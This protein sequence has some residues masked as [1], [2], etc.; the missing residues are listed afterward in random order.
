LPAIEIAGRAIGDG[1]PCFVIAEAGVN[2]N[3][4][5]RLARELVRVAAEAG[6]DAVKFQT[7]AAE[8]LATAAAPKASYQVARTERD[9][10]AQAMLRRLELD[11]DDHVQLIA[12]C[13]SAGVMFLSSA[14]DEASA[15]M[16]DELGVNA[17]KVPSGEITN[18]SYLRH[19]AAKKRPLIVSTGMSTLEEVEVAVAAIRETADVPLVLLHCVSLYPAP[20]AGTN[21]RAMETMRARF[22]VPVGY[23]DHTEGLT[24]ALA[25][26]ALGAAV[27]EKHFT[28]DRA[29]PGP[30]HAASLEPEEL[31][32]LVQGIRGVES[33]LGDG[34]KRPLP[35]EAE[36]AVVARKSVVAATD[37]QAG[38]AIERD[39]LA[40][41]RPGT[42][43]PPAKLDWVVGRAARRA[44][45]AGTLITEDMV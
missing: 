40:I 38:A 34:V 31:R 14:F 11:R 1:H 17:F 36:T 33:A 9:E 21:L 44:I 27:I 2:H 41:K 13:K 28:V 5:P 32:A 23:S 12:D 42:G 3:G 6:A 18:V 10:S 29:L 20:V 43:L 35:E 37:I 7:F 30:D 19:V 25:A 26:V 22:G 4:D 16:L 39:M 8:R 45:P 15:D 24:A